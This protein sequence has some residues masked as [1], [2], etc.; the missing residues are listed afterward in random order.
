MAIVGRRIKSLR[1][2]RN[3][4]Q[5][6]LALYSDVAQSHISRL[7]NGLIDSL[8]SEP[9]AKMVRVLNTTADYL[10][11]LTA[12]PRPPEQSTSPQTELEWQL[13]NTFRK[14]S[15]DEQRFVIAQLDLMLD[16]LTRPAVGVIGGADDDEVQETESIS[17]ADSA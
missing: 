17:R 15:V 5:G 12:N 16:L 14:L 4:T 1:E 6:Q 7:E 11:G 3:L 2:Q 8:G 13:L 10:L 9:L